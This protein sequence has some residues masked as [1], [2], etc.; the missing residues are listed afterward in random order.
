[1]RY[2]QPFFVG[3]NDKRFRGVS[4]DG[5]LPALDTKDVQPGPIVKPQLILLKMNVTTLDLNRRVTDLENSNQYLL[6]K[7]KELITGA[8]K[9]KTKRYKQYI[10]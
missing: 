2:D 10:T 8:S 4:A 5:Y 1:M 9:R 6:R 7:I 3:L